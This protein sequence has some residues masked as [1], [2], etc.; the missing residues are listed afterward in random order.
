MKHWSI[1]SMAKL[2]LQFYVALHIFI[3]VFNIIHNMTGGE[4]IQILNN[5]DWMLF[6][7]ACGVLAICETLDKA[8]KGVEG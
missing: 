4:F 6:I 1:T 8:L 5:E 7:I 3:V 2:F